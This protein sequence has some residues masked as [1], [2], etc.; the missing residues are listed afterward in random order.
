MT[1][2]EK[3]SGE[4]SRRENRQLLRRATVEYFES[5]SRLESA[6][7][8]SLVECLSLASANANFDEDSE[9]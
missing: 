8:Q 1:N 3:A 4:T 5:F 2:N 9:E 6:Q 7:D